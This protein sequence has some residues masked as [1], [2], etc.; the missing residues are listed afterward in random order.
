MALG[1]L[2]LSACLSS[3]YPEKRRAAVECQR[4]HGVDARTCED[5]ENRAEVE[6]EAYE[7]ESRQRWG[8]AD[9]G[10]DR[11][12]ADDACRLTP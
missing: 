8:C 7:T 1:L 6:Y 9:R 3:D 2:V 5:L 10:A 12:P 4:Q 11:W